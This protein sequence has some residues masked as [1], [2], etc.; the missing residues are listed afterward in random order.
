MLL[1]KGV[2]V[3]S[4]QTVSTVFSCIIFF[5]LLSLSYRDIFSSVADGFLSLCALSP[6]WLQC[7]FILFVVPAALEAEDETPDSPSVI[8]NN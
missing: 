6:E 7:P 2:I 5:F 4:V 1:L 8:V 3:S